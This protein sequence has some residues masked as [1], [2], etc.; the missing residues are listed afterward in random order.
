[1]FRITSEV[2]VLVPLIINDNHH[3][4]NQQKN[5]K[6]KVDFDIF[7]TWVLLDANIEAFEPADMCAGLTTHTQTHNQSIP[8]ES[9]MLNILKR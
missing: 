6:D 3:H 5:I 8:H 7:S 4:H 2:L 1:M 9:K